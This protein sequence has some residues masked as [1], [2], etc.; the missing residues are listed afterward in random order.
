MVKMVIVDDEYIILDS[1]K[2]LVDWASVGVEVIGA[3]D[4]GAAAVDFVSKHNTDIILSDISMPVFG[5]LEMLGALRKNNNNIEVIFISAHS[6]FEYAR[7]A[8]QHGAFDYILKPVNE[9][10]LLETV[11]RCAEKILGKREPPKSVWA[12]SLEAGPSKY[13]NKLKALQVGLSFEEAREML[14]Q[15]VKGADG[16]GAEAC[17]N[18]AFAGVIQEEDIFDSGLIKLK[19]VELLDYVLRGLED[20][21]LQ[22]YL[23]S[24][25]KVL[26]AK[27]SIN[28]CGTFDDAVEATGNMVANLVLCVKEILAGGSKQ[29]IS[30]AVSYIQGNYQ[31]DI[32]LSQIAE[33]LYI[34]PAYLSRVFSQEM[35]TP[36]TNYLREYRVNAAKKLLKESRLKIYE[37]AS[38]VGYTDVAH[39]SKSF[40]QVTGVTPARYRER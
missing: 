26:S 14:L 4:N 33:H 28:A 7:E 38:K 3:M 11:K 1:L 21:R 6:K 40:K 29:L 32:T 19:C 18:A 34:S 31:N 36:F 5:G 24:P 16:A 8:L 13:Y 17:L 30:L 35:G 20:Y 37:V 25:K 2:N 12:E 39:F 9:Q 22:D 10:Q 23:G 27:K 15:S